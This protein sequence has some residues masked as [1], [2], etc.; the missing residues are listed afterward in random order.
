[1]TLEDSDTS[2]FHDDAA[3]TTPRFFFVYR[4]EEDLDVPEF[5]THVRVDSGITAIQ[6]QA[7]RDCNDL[8]SVDIPVEGLTHIH[9]R[10]FSNCWS[11][12]EI[13]FP[14]SLNFI[15]TASFNDCHALT[16]VSLPNGLQAI[17]RF[18]FHDCMSLM[19][20]ALPP[21]LRVIREHAFAHCLELKSIELPEGLHTIESD[22]FRG[23]K[24]LIHLSIPSTTTEIGTTVFEDAIRLHEELDNNETG[25]L[26]ALKNRFRGLPVHQ[27]CYSQGFHPVE[28]TLD[29]LKE[30]VQLNVSSSFN[31]VDMF[32]T[33]VFHVLAL[34]SR[35]NLLLLKALAEHCPGLLDKQDKWMNRPI[36]Y[37]C[38]TD[39]PNAM[40]SIEFVVQVS[41]MDRLHWLGLEKWR[42]NV[43]IH[44]DLFFVATDRDERLRR[45]KPLQLSFAMYALMEKMALLELVLWKVKLDGCETMNP[46]DRQSCW[47]NCGAD[48]VISHVL[49][50]LGSPIGE[51]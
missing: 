27:L 2:G 39:A 49:P 14:Q 20:V 15:G 45:L 44:V 50:F 25:I 28:E 17:E 8:V 47:I 22:S 34:S 5:V 11:L 12:R 26:C 29:N 46:V 40:A 36:D 4:G 42:T 43:R 19:S 37:L 33:T 32:G 21:S 7:F 6:E 35:P 30:V 16:N 13:N 48:T 1:M 3:A 23:C 31:R 24:S 10:A 18:T 41:M 51:S 38:M 9:Y